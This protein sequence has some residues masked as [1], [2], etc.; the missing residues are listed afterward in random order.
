MK[1][2][3]LCVDII[4]EKLVG[5]KLVFCKDGL[6]IVGNVFGFNDGSVVLVLMSEEK[7]KEKG[8]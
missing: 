8:L 7:V 3:Y 4:V 6:V 2:E 5:L 1:D